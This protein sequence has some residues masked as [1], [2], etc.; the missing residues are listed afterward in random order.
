[1]KRLTE[2]I[3]DGKKDVNG[4]RKKKKEKWVIIKKEIRI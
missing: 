2:N 1:M 3:L 4:F